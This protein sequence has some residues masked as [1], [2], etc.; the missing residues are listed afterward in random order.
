M[1]GQL[2]F[3]KMAYQSLAVDAVL[4]CFK[5]QPNTSGIKY[6][7][8]PGL[9]KKKQP[10]FL[11]DSG[12][13]NT[14]L[15]LTEQHLLENI[16]KVQQ[17]QNLPI[18]TAL[19]KNKIT[20]INLDIEMETGTGKTYCYIKSMFEMNIRFGWSKF[21]V[22]VP[23]IAIRE[24]VY[25]SLQI[26]ADHFQESYGKKAK[27]FIYNSK[28]LH[29]L[30]S[31]SSDAGIN[32]MVINVQAFNATGKDARRIYEELDDFQTRRP[33]DVIKANRPIMILDEPQKMEGEK[34]LNSLQAFKPL[35]I[36]RYSATH[37][38]SHNKIHRLDALD[39]YNQKLVKKIAVRGISVK[40]LSGTNAY[41]YLESIEISKQSPI[42]RLE[43]ETK[44]KSGLIKRNIRKIQ[45]SDNLFDL[46]NEL[47]QYKGFVVSDI[48]ANT[49]TISFTNGVEISAGEATGDVNEM[50]LR[51]IQIRE[52]I[53]AHL[54]KEKILF[55][56]GIKTLSLFFI[57]EVAKY[58]VYTDAGQ[59]GG[60]YA[61]IFEEEYQ[62][63]VNEI[64]QDLFLHEEYR[65]YLE[66]IAA[67]ITHNGYFS[68]DKK[69][70]LIDP[71]LSGRGNDKQCN[72]V[73]ADRKSTRL[74]SSHTDIS[75]MPS[76]A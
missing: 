33:I 56:Q 64:L 15:V 70:K 68:I 55:N 25:K 63:C 72:D 37:K 13:K 16:Q 43:I 69:G 66:N 38:T 39:A 58:R 76:S 40:G 27:F 71:K 26:T 48:D 54:E 35:M 46:S 18:S 74:N 36:L 50:A 10:A 52:A 4:D 20:S 34:T 51:R 8:D 3:K 29:N 67:N 60:E 32:I 2:K 19:V 24:G 7:I 59:E 62:D 12:F 47:D 75:R 61:K 28:Q 49:D 31:F 41:L 5:G 21:I 9:S 17:L 65:K 1:M 45:K 44:Q 14:D 30:E 11:E 22:V 42:A 57:D 6:R 53:K 23:S 73:D